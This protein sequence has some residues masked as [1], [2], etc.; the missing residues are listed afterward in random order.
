MKKG[1][2]SNKADNREDGMGKPYGQFK[3][4]SSAFAL[5]IACLVGLATAQT[6]LANFGWGPCPA[7]RV[8]VGCN[9]SVISGLNYF[10]AATNA[11]P[12]YVIP[13]ETVFFNASAGP[14]FTSCC[15][16]GGVLTAISPHNNS[17]IQLSGTQIP[18]TCPDTLQSCE[19]GS[20][21]SVQGA[22]LSYT[23]DANDT[24]LANTVESEGNGPGSCGLAGIPHIAF[25]STYRNGFSC[26]A[27]AATA[28]G[29]GSACAQ[30][31]I[32]CISVTK[33]VACHTNN[34]DCSLATYCKSATGFIDDQPAAS[35]CYSIT[36]TNCGTD[37]LIVT[38]ITDNILSGAPFN[39]DLNSLF[40]NANP[41]TP[42][43][44]LFPATG[45]LA[46][47]GAATAV[48]IFF[49]VNETVGETNTVT[50]DSF[51]NGTGL[52]FP[53]PPVSDTATTTVL[54]ASISCS[55]SAT[56]PDSQGSSPT[57][58]VELFSDGVAH[59]V[60]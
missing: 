30:V 59:S 51:E 17:T 41:N 54:K 60:T 13:G 43:N 42:N 18:F 36:V 49:S 8:G 50:V 21:S 47:P 4:G 44:E 3:H 53:L 12:V 23:V 35:F 25:S 10:D 28:S 37:P 22:L 31:L 33:L 24:N 56:S 55:V 2:T 19:L 15:H 11:F 7:N 57:C 9:S 45:P 6:A 5:R 52:G 16:S 34:Q 39:I 29:Q 46:V 26:S 20:S 58:N 27:S 48:T 38:N 32:P 14:N 1:H 40:Q